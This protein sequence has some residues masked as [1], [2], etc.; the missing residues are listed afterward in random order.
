MTKS[1]TL[2][3]LKKLLIKIETFGEKNNLSLCQTKAFIYF[4]KFLDIAENVHCRRIKVWHYN[5]LQHAPTENEVP[6]DDDS[7]I[8][9]SQNSFFDTVVYEQ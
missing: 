9:K 2:V 5:E 4:K 3:S 1:I 6:M 8:E 7:H